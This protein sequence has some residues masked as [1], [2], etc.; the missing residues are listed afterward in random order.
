M[1]R[2]W[3]NAASNFSLERMIS[4]PGSGGRWGMPR[5]SAI[6]INAWIPACRHSSPRDCRGMS[7]AVIASVGAVEHSFEG[8]HPMV[9]RVG[10][11]EETE[12]WKGGV[13]FAELDKP[14]FPALPHLL[15]LIEPSE[16]PAGGKQGRT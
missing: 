16:L 9:V 1:S 12:L 14:V 2:R 11:A 13:G 4:A 10:R 6:E 8:K 3:L 7:Q 5:K 15:Q